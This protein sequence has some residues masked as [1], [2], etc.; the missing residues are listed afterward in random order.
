V[1][2]SPS[3]LS[4]RTKLWLSHGV[5][6]ALGLIVA[7]LLSWRA[8]TGIDSLEPMFERAP[9]SDAA[10]LAYR[11]GSANDGASALR[12]YATLLRAKAEPDA[13][14]AADAFFAR[15][16]LAI[17]EDQP[18]SELVRL[19]AEWTHCTPANLDRLVAKAAAERHVASESHNR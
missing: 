1:T 11:W 5:A 7:A 6:L 15:L 14:E 4:L 2:P 9:L 16:R 18:R 8:R 13:L 3:G 10:T 17:L 19:C 12:Q